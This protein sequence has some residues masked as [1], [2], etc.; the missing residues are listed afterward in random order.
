[1][2]DP[3]TRVAA[4]RTRIVL[5]AQAA[6]RAP[7]RLM[8][9]PSVNVRRAPM[10]AWTTDDI[11]DQSGRT[12][13]VTGANAGLGYQTAVQLARAGAHVLLAARDPGRGAAALERLRA[14]VPA[15]RAELLPLHLADLGSVER[16]AAGF[17]P[18]RRRPG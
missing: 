7:D 17:P 2:P 16:F 8:A 3:A 10:A 15:S 12:A 11:P 9:V 5:S 4:G 1:M 6:A 14:E 18:Q 13:I